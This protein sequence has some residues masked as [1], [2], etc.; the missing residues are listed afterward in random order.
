MYTVVVSVTVLDRFNLTFILTSKCE[1]L[2]KCYCDVG[3][4]SLTQDQHYTCVDSMSRICWENM[5]DM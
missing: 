1:T 5:E 3:P 2:I 4:A